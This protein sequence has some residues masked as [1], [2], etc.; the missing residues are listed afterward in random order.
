MSNSEI[1]S[2]NLSVFRSTT[3]C[4]V[5]TGAV[6]QHTCHIETLEREKVLS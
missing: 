6:V 5:I 2:L 1:S 4:T 3:G